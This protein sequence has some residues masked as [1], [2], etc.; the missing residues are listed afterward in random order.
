MLILT[1]DGTGRLQANNQTEDIRPFSVLGIR[2]EANLVT[3]RTASW[4]GI[5]V[6]FRP[7]TQWLAWLYWPERSSGITMLQLDEDDVEELHKQLQ[8]AM[9]YQQSSQ[10]RGLAMA[11]NLLER[12]ILQCDS[13]FQLHQQAVDPRIQRVLLEIELNLHKPL[14]VSEL[15]RQATLS[16]SRFAYLFKSQLGISPQQYIERERMHH[17][18][19]SLLESE[20][21]IQD[22][23]RDIG[24]DDPF[25]FSTR[26][27]RHF[28]VSPKRW[29]ESQ[30]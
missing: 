29:R 28:G 7:K 27:A 8:E 16:P 12:F 9:A 21:Q 19:Q 5:Q 14:P 30:R 3:S 18:A 22:I 6:L 25:Y 10:L 26:F 20:R 23:A 24:F 13:H 15:A 17:A 1:L 2:P 11:V 4:R